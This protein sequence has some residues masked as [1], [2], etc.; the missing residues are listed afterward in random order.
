M[1]YQTTSSISGPS[2]PTA[3]PSNGGVAAGQ[4]KEEKL[5]MPLKITSLS[6][7][8]ATGVT[9]DHSAAQ[10]S[11]AAGGGIVGPREKVGNDN[12]TGC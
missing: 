6:V 2:S 8:K 7:E 3:G 12:V 10:M 4:E 1:V 9:E 11:P 5:R